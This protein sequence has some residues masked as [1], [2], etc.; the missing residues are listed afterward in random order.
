MISF[1]REL[2]KKFDLKLEQASSLERVINGFSIDEKGNVKS[3]ALNGLNLK[4]LEILL[5]ISEYLSELLIID[6]DLNNLDFLESFRNLKNLD[7][8]F[9]ELNEGDFEKIPSLKKLSALRLKRTNIKDTSVL[10]TLYSL[11]NLFIGYNDLYEV[12]G[13]EGL[14]ML[15]DI[16]LRKTKI[17]HIDKIH[18]HSAIHSM[19]LEHTQIQK[20]A[21]LD[22][23]V[24]LL[25][26][27]LSDNK[28]SKIEGLDH[29]ESLKVLS[30]CENNFSKI[31]GL[32][33]LS[34][35]EVLDLFGDDYYGGE[36]EKIEGLD[37]L[38]NLKKINLS[39]HRIS[40][41]ENL[42]NLTKLDTIWFDCNKI[43]EFDTSFLSGLESSCIIALVG[44][45][46]RKI[47]GVIPEHVK[48]EFDNKEW[49]PRKLGGF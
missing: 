41:V 48:I 2:E 31:E 19:N 30:L 4:S 35:L 24:N 18:V 43:T 33:A 22:R 39:H 13:L 9:N 16:N 26:L 37:K 47:D 10:G 15:K 11:E 7:L 25:R 29:L 1:I 20:I 14:T 34:S 32:E 44:N 28:I 23:F 36:I 46:L 8:S 45:P 6:C 21:G 3:L 42:D 5:P 49:A 27:N 40:K 38:V 17:D 12:K